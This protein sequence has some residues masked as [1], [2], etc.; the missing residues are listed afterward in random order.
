VHKENTGQ[1]NVIFFSVIRTSTD[2]L[3][4]IFMLNS[5]MHTE[6]FYRAVSKIQRIL[7][8]QNSTLRGHETGRNFPLKC[9]GI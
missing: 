3:S 9:T 7:N 5:D 1:Q 8:V 6:C 2:E 4:S